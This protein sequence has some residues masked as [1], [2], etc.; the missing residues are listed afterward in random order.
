[1][2]GGT[3]PPPLPKEATMIRY[4]ATRDSKGART[5]E[6]A[7]MAH[8]SIYSGESLDEARVAL[9]DYMR[10]EADW[11]VSDRYRSATGLRRAADILE[12]ADR[13]MALEPAEGVPWSQAAVSSQTG[14][15]VELVWKIIRTER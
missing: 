3:G 10:K 6:D 13:V 15:T 1:M 14:D 7:A 5:D 2:S 8:V 12:A 11:L 4:F 9:R